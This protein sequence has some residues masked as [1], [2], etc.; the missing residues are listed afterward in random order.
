MEKNNKTDLPDGFEYIVAPP[1]III[2]FNPEYKRLYLSEY[3]FSEGLAK[4]GS[5]IG[6]AYNKEKDELLIDKQGTGFRISSDGYIFAKQLYEFL[7]RRSIK[8]NKDMLYF[9]LDY[10]QQNTDRFLIF[11]MFERGLNFD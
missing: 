2:H 8:L 9:E 10:N 4:K 5:T 11:K 7:L 3:I 6:L 1:R